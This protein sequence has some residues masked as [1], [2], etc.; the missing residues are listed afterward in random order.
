M[1]YYLK[2]TNEKEGVFYINTVTPNLIRKGEEIVLSLHEGFP[3]HHLE[4]Y[5]N[6]KEL[7]P[8]LNTG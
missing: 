7:P 3:G 8:I 6:K 5:Y 1:A 4:S 2:P